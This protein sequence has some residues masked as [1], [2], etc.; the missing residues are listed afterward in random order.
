MP[1]ARR[2][3]DPW[4]QAIGLIIRSQVLK[5]AGTYGCSTIGEAH[6]HKVGVLRH[7]IPEHH[8]LC[9]NAAFN[10]R[11]S[12]AGTDRRLDRVRAVQAASEVNDVAAS[13]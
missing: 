5:L 10:G 13:L 11:A 12:R 2:S 4:C 7:Y 9:I 6:V 8:Y 3:T 1:C